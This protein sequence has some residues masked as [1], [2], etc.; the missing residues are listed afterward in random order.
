M[1]REMKI[2]DLPSDKSRL[3]RRVEEDLKHRF[4]L[5]PDDKIGRGGRV[6]DAAIGQPVIEIETKLRAVLGHT[7]PASFQKHAAFSDEPRLFVLR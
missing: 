6:N 1:H 7:P 5:L 4:L 2:A 3:I